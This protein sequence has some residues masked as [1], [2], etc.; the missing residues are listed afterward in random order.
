MSGCTVD[1]TFCEYA[2]AYTDCVTRIPEGLSSAEAA[3]IMCAVCI[4][5]VFSLRVIFN[6][7]CLL[8]RA[9]LFIAHFRKAEPMRVIG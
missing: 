4:Y 2:V 7:N 5:S 3:S 8:Y 6:C 1:G 9:S